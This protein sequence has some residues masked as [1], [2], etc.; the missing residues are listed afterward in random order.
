MAAW[1]SLPRSIHVETESQV[2]L[3]SLYYS[4]KPSS[5][6]RVSQ[7]LGLPQSLMAQYLFLMSNDFSVN[8]T[9][10]RGLT[11]KQYHRQTGTEANVKK[12]QSAQA[13]SMAP[14][15][16]PARALNNTRNP[17]SRGTKGAQSLIKLCLQPLEAANF[18]T[19]LENA[20]TNTLEPSA[21]SEKS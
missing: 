2:V 9:Y 19:L 3:Y 7:K 14:V 10:F 16:Q 18:I 13:K 17:Q 21:E 12:E 1:L 5:C 8:G 6:A 11:T 20:L 4:G 15:K